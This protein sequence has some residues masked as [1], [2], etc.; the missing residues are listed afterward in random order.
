MINTIIFSYDRPIQLEL[1][2]RSMAQHDTDSLLR[3]SILYTFSGEEFKNGYDKLRL[4]YPAFSWIKED[5]F[6][7]KFVLPFLPVYWHN[8]YWW[9]RYKSCR[10]V[11]SD[12]RK[13]L[14]SI[15][16]G[17]REKYCCF[18]TD[19]SMFYSPVSVP[20]PVLEH[21]EE[22][23]FQFS[24]SLRH[25]QN[26]EG[27]IYEEK[28]D[29]L[30]WKV[31]TT[32]LAP[33]WSYPFSVDGHIYGRRFIESSLAK[34]WFKNPNSLEGNI[35]CYAKE[36][37]ILSTIYCNKESSLVGFELNRVQE[38]CANNNLNIENKYLNSLFNE[39]YSMKIDFDKKLNRFFRPEKFRV[40]AFR[41]T[42]SINI[43][44]LK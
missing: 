28:D 16:T 26:I 4:E 12:F 13:K 29:M 32:G 33:E 34:V 35:A 2:L 11:A 31:N 27:G 15:I 8:Y 42:E 7:K 19:D 43:I 1:L 38:Q 21:I 6:N 41:E 3:V 30:R 14:R 25:G 5:R 20:A 23:P 44:T 22:D 36:E 24:F 10:T 18:L 40:D 17:G 39:G 9:L 37:K